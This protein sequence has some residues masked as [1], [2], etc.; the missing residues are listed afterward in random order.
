MQRS[1][2]DTTAASGWAAALAHTMWIDE[3]SWIMIFIAAV[4]AGCG[5]PDSQPS[6]VDLLNGTPRF[7]EEAP[8]K[9]TV[10]SNAFK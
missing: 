8:M 9:L 5:R 6:P 10:R 7:D 1:L 2:S 3:T 4:M